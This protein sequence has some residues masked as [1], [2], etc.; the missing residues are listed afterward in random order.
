[1]YGFGN[2]LP[3][4]DL[5]IRPNARRILVADALWADTSRLAQNQARICPLCIILGHQ[6]I[7]LENGV[8]FLPILYR[9]SVKVFQ[10]HFSNLLMIKSMRG[11]IGC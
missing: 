1:V 10:K 4:F 2:P 6:S 11:F 9:K 8:D 7:G 5:L 3:T